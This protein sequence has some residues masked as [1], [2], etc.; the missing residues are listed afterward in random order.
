MLSAFAAQEFKRLEPGTRTY[1]IL[2]LAGS[3]LCFVT[4]V[5]DRQ[6]GFILLEGSWALVSA[7]GLWRVIRGPRQQLL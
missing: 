5:V 7:W 1:Q 3:F 4:A 2:N 6:Y